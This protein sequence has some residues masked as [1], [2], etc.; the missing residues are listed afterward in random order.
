MHF[1]PATL[2]TFIK[3]DM[4]PF[5]KK[6]KGLLSVASDPYNFLELLAQAPSG[7]CCIL[8]SHSDSNTTQEIPDAAFLANEIHVGVT[9]NL[10]LTATP[11]EQ[12]AKKRPGGAPSLLELVGLTRDRMRSMVF[13]DGVTD[14]AFT[15]LGRDPV[16]LPEGVPLA[17]YRLRFSL[18]T[19]DAPI[20]PRT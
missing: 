2:L 9:C 3:D 8:H 20:T 16:V 13:P 5:V 14:G 7:W 18:M 6:Q 4:A 15:Y 1:T 17:A 12:I 19:A 10:G 11:G